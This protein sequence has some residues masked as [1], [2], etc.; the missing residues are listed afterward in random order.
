MRRESRKAIR[1]RALLRP[2]TAAV[3]VT[4]RPF[5][6]APQGQHGYRTFFV[7]QKFALHAIFSTRYD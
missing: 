5:L 6:R 3:T 7:I 1:A 4:C 2:I